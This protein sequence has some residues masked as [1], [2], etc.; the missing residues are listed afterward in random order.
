MARLLW[1]IP[2]LLIL[3]ALWGMRWAQPA[4]KDRGRQS[5]TEFDLPAYP[6]GFDFK[7]SA[8]DPL[9]ES[10]AYLVKDGS[11]DQVADYYRAAMTRGRYRVQAEAPMTVDLP[12]AH[13]TDPPRYTHGR[14]ILFTSA[15]EDRAVLLMA[16]DQPLRGARTQV[17]LAFG[18][19]SYYRAKGLLPR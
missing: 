3:A 5:P 2:A 16:I 11:P 8:A 6:G 13:P 9:N 18:P 17:S 1:F 12:R 4:P 7:S 19:L 14:R 10:V 15:E